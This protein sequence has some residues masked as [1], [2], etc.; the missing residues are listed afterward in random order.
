MRRRFWEKVLR[1]VDTTG[2]ASQL[3]NQLKV[4]HEAA[5]ATADQPLGHVVAA[6][7]IYNQ[8]SVNLLQTGVI[9]KEIAEIIGRLSAG[10]A[11]DQLK[12]RI[13]SLVLLI[14]KLPTDPTADCGVRATADMLG[15]L[16][17]DDLNHGK[18]AIRTQVPKL[19]QELA[20]DA[21]SCPC[22][23]A[24]GL[25]TG[26]KPRKAPSGTTPFAS[27]RLTYEEICSAWTTSA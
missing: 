19:L 15:D 26:C 16:L 12:S 8:I 21:W 27:K 14:G 6:D 1:I 11:D 7:F 4:I 10:D 3:R 17:I 2:T 5:Q 25:N 22:K 20:D 9:S 23:P 13:L 18:D 24:L